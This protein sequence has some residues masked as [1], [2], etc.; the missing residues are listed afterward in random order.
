M[1]EIGWGEWQRSEGQGF[2]GHKEKGDFIPKIGACEGAIQQWLVGA[3]SEK[4]APAQGR[5][6]EYRAKRKKEDG[7]EDTCGGLTGQRCSWPLPHPLPTFPLPLPPA[8]ECEQLGQL[9][10][11]EPVVTPSVALKSATEGVCTTETCAKATHQDCMLWTLQRWLAS[12]LPHTETT[13][14]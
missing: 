11:C 1:G 10:P 3:M 4:G 12:T 8:T 2:M 9:L 14:P 5:R 7:L 6:K 13:A